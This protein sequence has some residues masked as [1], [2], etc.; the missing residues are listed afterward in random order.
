MQIYYVQYV[1]VCIT[2][3]RSMPTQH[4]MDRYYMYLGPLVLEYV[5]S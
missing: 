4:M 3:Y 1:Y 2:V 5:C